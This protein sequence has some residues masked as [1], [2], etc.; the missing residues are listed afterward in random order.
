[1]PTRR[2]GAA[3]MWRLALGILLLATAAPP[4]LAW[5]T[6]A[7]GGWRAVEITPAAPELLPFAGFEGNEHS[8]MGHIALWD[9]GVEDC[10]GLGLAGTCHL[11]LTDLNS[12]LFHPQLR[13]V[14]TEYD[15]PSTALEERLLPP[16]AHFSGMPDY[17][18]SIYDWANKNTLCPALPPG[19]D[20]QLPG[21]PKTWGC[22]DFTGWM[23]FFNANHFGSQA[24]HMY[25]L[26]HGIA[27]NLAARAQSMRTLLQA[28]PLPR[29]FDAHIDYVYEAELEALVFEAYGQHFLQDRWSSG[30]MWER[31]NGADFE[32]AVLAET[33]QAGAFAG[34]LHGSQGITGL[35]DPM[36]SPEVVGSV[37]T[38]ALPV[39]YRIG[40][41]APESSVGDYRLED[42]F[43]GGFG[44][45]H[46]LNDMSIDVSLQKD[47]WIACSSA[48]WGEVIEAFGRDGSG[49]GAWNVELP[50]RAFGEVVQSAECWNN[51]STNEAIA[52]G[53]V[54]DPLVGTASGLSRA[55][56]SPASEL[57][58]LI[59]GRTS[60]VEMTWRIRRAANAAPLATTLAR[61][62]IGKL[63]AVP[64]GDVFAFDGAGQPTSPDYAEPEDLDTL[65]VNDTTGRGRD[66]RTLYGLFNRAH[67][68][69]WCEDIQFTLSDYRGVADPISQ[70]VCQYLADRVYK[71]TDPTYDGGR[72]EVRSYGG[73]EV[74]PICAHYGVR[75][76]TREDALP[77]YLH[78]GYVAEPD[79]VG[80]YAHRSVEA[81]C[82]RVPVIDAIDGAVPGSPCWRLD[83]SGDDQDV[84]AVVETTGGEA[85][86]A[87]MDFGAPGEVWA[88]PTEAGPWTSVISVSSWSA[89]SIVLAV[90]PN[91][92]FDAGDWF[93]QVRPGG[94]GEEGWSV[95]RFILR[96]AP[97]PPAQPVVTEVDFLGPLVPG[98]P[99]AF[100]VTVF[101]PETA[102]DLTSGGESINVTSP[103]LA[104]GAGVPIAGP[105][106]GVDA[107][108]A[109]FNG[110]DDVVKPINDR[111]GCTPPEWTVTSVA[112]DSP[113]FPTSAPVAV[114]GPPFD[115]EVTV[116]NVAPFVDPAFQHPPLLVPPGGPV[117]LMLEVTDDNNDGLAGCDELEPQDVQVTSVSPDGLTTIPSLDASLSFDRTGTDGSTGVSQFRAQVDVALPHADNDDTPVDGCQVP[118]SPPYEVEW[119]AADDAGLGLTAPPQPILVRVANVA[120]VVLDVDNQPAA[121]HP[122]HPTPVTFDVEVA[123]DNFADDVTDVILD[124]TACGGPPDFGLDVVGDPRNGEWRGTITLTASQT[125]NVAVRAVDDNC[126]E[127]PLAHLLTVQ[128]LPPTWTGFIA[129]PE[130]DW[131]E[132]Q[133]IDHVV[134]FSDANGD[135]LEVI[136]IV[137]GPGGRS[138]HPMQLLPSGH[139]GGSFPAPCAGEYTVTYRATEKNLPPG[140]TPHTVL[141]ESWQLTV[142]EGDPEDCPACHPEGRVVILTYPT[143]NLPAETPVCL[144]EIAQGGCS[145]GA[146]PPNCDVEHLHSFE[147]GIF[148]EGV[149]GGPY[150]DPQI[151]VGD[152]CGFGEITTSPECGPDVVPACF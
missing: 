65:P 7:E 87:G 137:E 134:G 19:H 119:E 84:V 140:A 123:D 135:E 48:G 151:L 57:F 32:S 43:D 142:R 27:L 98:E 10:F 121:L 23:G 82:R 74:D 69:Y 51:W 75:S 18:W 4:A 64:S 113:A 34:L 125:C 138:E 11:T 101:D 118:E 40:A 79:A 13:N 38:V 30:H 45:E 133:P 136:A 94:V 14:P 58:N 54:D 108:S 85:P 68:D 103:A 127:G 97:G 26:Y 99:V 52:T 71:G 62:G 77:Y 112:T 9:L 132:C 115:S 147:G 111:S 86:L 61:G 88:R 72:V 106:T 8:E 39:E 66:K 92:F 78:P 36:C 124:L 67:A 2:A 16:P 129:G 148:I 152:A 100:D 83:A 128:N 149:P 44:L 89:T 24:R 22:H 90:P 130:G 116:E 49:Y 15:D 47:R 5:D 46:Q 122:N 29:D 102:D 63:G 95:G 146:H 120:P 17:S 73:D 53:W 21:I 104:A 56:L 28:S 80:Q 3:L 91:F 50:D 31:W 12:A 107:C 70:E 37:A 76:Q 105:G 25:L 144:S 41:G 96:V 131:V 93:L 6:K 139:Y 145:F 126:A 114:T 117:Q 150:E 141:S 42:M 55:V 110:T 143:G 1:V 109:V 59:A 60:L 20:R 81:W 33:A 35:P